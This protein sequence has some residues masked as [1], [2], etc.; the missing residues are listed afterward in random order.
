LNEMPSIKKF[1]NMDMDELLSFKERVEEEIAKREEVNKPAVDFEEIL[2]LVGEVRKL[3][4]DTGF[5]SLYKKMDEFLPASA[6][7][8]G[9]LEEHAKEL[10]VETKYDEEILPISPE[11]AQPR[12]AYWVK[13][14]GN[15]ARKARKAAEEVA[16]IEE[17]G[18]TIHVQTVDEEMGLLYPTLGNAI[19]DGCEKAGWDYTRYNGGWAKTVTGLDKTRTNGYS[20]M[21]EFVNSPCW[22]TPGSL[23]LDCSKGGSRK[24]QFWEYHLFKVEGTGQLTPLEESSGKTWAVDLWPA[25]EKNL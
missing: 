8:F 23:L 22:L 17:N 10:G 20:L 5:N 11:A 21:G 18:H 24:N 2:A 16:F 1:E 12:V 25:V 15:T 4:L 19:D 7:L 3:G 13:E 6:D 14:I 9:R